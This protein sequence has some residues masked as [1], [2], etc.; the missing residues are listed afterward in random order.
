MFAISFVGHQYI[1][2]QSYYE[3]KYMRNPAQNTLPVAFSSA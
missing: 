2:I 1:K 3:R